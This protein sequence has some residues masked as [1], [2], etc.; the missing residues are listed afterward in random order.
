MN[1]RI[2]K[3]LFKS[4]KLRLAERHDAQ[5]R[6]WKGSTDRRR[7]VIF[8]IIIIKFKSSSRKDTFKWWEA[9]EPPE[10]L[11]KRLN[12]RCSTGSAAFFQPYFRLYFQPLYVLLLFSC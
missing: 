5:R 9:V 11:N 1:S 2:F 10:D 4:G 6:G 8:L 7:V 3:Q 12:W